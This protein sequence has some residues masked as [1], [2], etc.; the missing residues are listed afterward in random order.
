MLTFNCNQCGKCC[1][2]AI[3]LTFNEFTDHAGELPALCRFEFT[4]L[5][6]TENLHNPLYIL[7]SHNDHYYAIRPEIVSIAGDRGCA[8]LDENNL[9]KIYENRPKACN[10]FPVDLSADL[11]TLNQK[12]LKKYNVQIK[13]KDQCEGFSGISD[14]CK[15]IENFQTSSNNNLLKT[16]KIENL[17]TYDLLHDY[18]QYM[19]L[20]N[21]RIKKQLETKHLGNIVCYISDFL[22]Y[23]YTQKIIPKDKFNHLCSQQKHCFHK[24]S[25]NVDKQTLPSGSVIQNLAI[26]NVKLLNEL[27]YRTL[28]YLPDPLRLKVDN[29]GD[30]QNQ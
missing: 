28:T 17:I 27:Y 21:S 7:L 18:F 20:S 14:D 15:S 29:N 12:M 23:L 22:Y 10:L 30:L 16:R 9:C 26:I 6:S 1:Q 24:L 3:P 8:Q 13:L 2:K 11:S 4:K 25:S 19:Y 5:E